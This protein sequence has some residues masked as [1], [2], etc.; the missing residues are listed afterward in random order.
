MTNDELD[1]L[2]ALAAAA[3]P[4]PWEMGTGK[5]Y[6]VLTLTEVLA[7]G[8]ESADAAF[9]AAARD[10]VPALVAE[11]RR[12]REVT[13]PV[14]LPDGQQ[15]AMGRVGGSYATQCVDVM[16]QLYPV[17]EAEELAIVDARE[18]V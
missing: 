4:G 6:N 15:I 14:T 9:I 11:V 5:A 7:E 16:R 8:L 10:A 1:T 13:R 18:G 12:L 17:Q 2:D 3:T